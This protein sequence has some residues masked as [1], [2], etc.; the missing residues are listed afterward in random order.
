MRTCTKCNVAQPL[1][2]FAFK[3]NS[4]DKLRQ[5]CQPCY[6]RLTVIGKRW[7]ASNPGAEKAAADRFRESGKARELRLRTR[8]GISQQAYDDILK[9]QDGGC[10]ICGSS[11]PGGRYEALH[12]DHCHKRRLYI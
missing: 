2:S 8:Y 1:T 7:S 4:K 12:V 6:E 5:R 3:S 9:R 10:A 11:T